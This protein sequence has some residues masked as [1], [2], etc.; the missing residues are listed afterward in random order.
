M[1]IIFILTMTVFL[2][3][4]QEEPTQNTTTTA[5]GDTIIYYR[6]PDIDFFQL[7]FCAG[8]HGCDAVDCIDIDCD[9]GKLS[10]TSCSATPYP[11]QC[12]SQEGTTTVIV[13]IS[14]VRYPGNTYC[15]NNGGV[16]EPSYFGDTKGV[17][18]GS[19]FDIPPQGWPTASSQGLSIDC[20]TG[21]IDIDQSVANGLFGEYPKNGTERKIRI[22]Y[23]LNDKSL[24]TLNYT[25][26][27]FVYESSTESARAAA[28]GPGSG[29]VV[30]VKSC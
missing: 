23:R 20:H 18:E 27:T 15:T 1:K 12:I 21:K 4:C 16:S 8:A 24:Y 11:W 25:D 14:G 26:I 28:Q 5:S 2:F 7:P 29:T 17:P 6:Q 22:Y 19:K 3:A 30:I 9:A 13:L 10:A